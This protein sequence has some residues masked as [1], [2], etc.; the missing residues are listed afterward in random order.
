MQMIKEDLVFCN[1]CK[2]YAT[3]LLIEELENLAIKS[4][5][6]ILQK[7]QCGVC[8]RFNEKLLQF[9]SSCGKH[10]DQKLI[11][12]KPS[13]IMAETIDQEF[14]CNN[15]Q[16]LNETSRYSDKHIERWLNAKDEEGGVYC[17]YCMCYKKQELV[18]KQPSPKGF[19]EDKFDLTTYK[20]KT[21]GHKNY[22]TE[23][24]Q[25]TR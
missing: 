22:G 1:T 23:H 5:D 24:K 9:C 2:D 12:E 15:C 25:D 16:N 20:C 19:G 11:S 21:C 18:D 8:K 4:T 10:T 14:Q 6:S 13:E 17:N 7:F 3:Q